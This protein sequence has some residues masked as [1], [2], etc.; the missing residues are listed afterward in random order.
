M[1]INSNNKHGNPLTTTNRI[2]TAN[3]R[4]IIDFN[5][6]SGV[7]HIAYSDQFVGV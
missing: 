1:V 7:N 2:T 3:K 4:L 5:L 6:Y